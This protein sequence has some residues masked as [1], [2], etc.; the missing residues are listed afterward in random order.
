MLFDQEYIRIQEGF[1][2]LTSAAL[3]A[4]ADQAAPVSKP[5]EGILRAQ[6]L[7]PGDPAAPPRKSRAPGLRPA[8]R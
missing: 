5:D 2:R 7:R 6:R 1:R 3:L 8:G 4:F